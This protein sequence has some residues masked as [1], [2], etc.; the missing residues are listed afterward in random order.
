MSLM[1]AMFAT[2]ALAAPAESP[3]DASG[4]RDWSDTL[5]AQGDYRGALDAAGHAREINR[6]D[7]WAAYAWA[8]ALAAVDPGTARIAIP[9]LQDP[10]T[11]QALATE[12]RAKLNAALGY[13]CLELELEP[14]A[15][16][17]FNDVPAGTQSHAGA[18]AGLAI[19]A[20]RR[21]DSRQALI[22][23]EAARVSG[24]LDPPLAE[25]ERET[26]FRVALHEFTTARDLRDAN[27]ASRSY[28]TLD[29]L[30][31]NHPA[32]LRARA[33]LAQLRG[34]APARERA[35]RDLLAIDR[36]APGAANQLVDT[37]LELRRPSEALFVAR[38][39]APERL[40]SDAALQ[41]IERHWVS[42]F[43]AAVAWRRRDG[44]TGLGRLD[45]PQLQLAWVTSSPRWGHFR[46][47]ADAQ[48]PD[49][50]NVAAG[51]PYGSSPSLP[52]ATSSQDD[53]GLGVLAQWAPRT[54]LVI[55]LGHTPPSY[56]VANV[57]GALRFRVDTEEGPFSFG[58]ERLPVTDSLLSLAGA[59]DPVTG[60]EWGGVMRNRAYV[61]G[62]LG[63]EDLNI[64]GNF[65]GA[66]ID[67]Q[68]V[69]DNTHW[70]AGV[71]FWRRAASGQ[72]WQARLGGNLT[73]MGFADNLSH[74]TIGHGGYFSP[75]RFISVGP[76]FD[77]RGRR[78]SASFRI[79][80][81]LSWQQMREAAS[82]YF[83]DDPVLQAA[84][85]NP[86]YTR[87]SREG[88]GARLS[89]TVEWRV[90]NRAVA[91]VRLEGVRGEDFDEVRLQVYTR[92]W[93]SA[94]TEPAQ[95]PPLA[96]LPP[97]F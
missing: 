11:M 2:L 18:Q 4:W 19:L 15:A 56:S 53:D 49:A 63:G 70:E 67:G 40:A 95:E 50:G 55:E 34:D 12:D 10:A 48:A 61:A 94:V 79:E 41:A 82:A 37:L 43:D 64:Y 90:S 33:D 1:V 32:T 28:A 9:G 7:P 29:E 38:D 84:S 75:S 74:F 14:L 68:R 51:R 44:A 88:I 71:G 93:D 54:G 13:L 25:L 76:A 73:A 21:G 72:G 31:P 91:G 78:D 85:G 89:A 83:P 47:A 26:R 77:F 96:V 27:A 35:L 16:M 65:S 59:S 66:M 45:A 23:F 39:L 52:V 8:R 3:R 58:L 60:R 57:V 46:I 6:T 22:H 81:G 24:K 30:R 97:V 20:V 92:R 86:R 69:D 42:H 36:S 62:S 80:G 17:H 5:Y 87:S